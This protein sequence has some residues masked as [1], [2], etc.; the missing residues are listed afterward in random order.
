MQMPLQHSIDLVRRETTQDDPPPEGMARVPGGRFRMGSETG[1]DAE[2]PVHFVKV[3]EFYI[4]RALVS[5]GDFTHFVKE[6]GYLT[7]AELGPGNLATTW[8]TYNTGSRRDH[9]VILVSWFDATAYA[10]WSGK[11]LPTEA[12]WEKAARGGSEGDLY[13]WETSRR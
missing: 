7:T 11:A 4:D 8:R 6:T 2:Q 9:P 10:R 3:D 13:P 12:Q 1:S 5:N